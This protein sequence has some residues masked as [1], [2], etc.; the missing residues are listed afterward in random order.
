MLKLNNISKKFSNFELKDISFEVSAGEYFVILGKSGAGKSV[1]LELIAGLLHPDKGKIYQENKNITNLKIQKRNFGLVFQNHSLFP[2]MSVKENILYPLKAKKIYDKSSIDQLVQLC[3]LMGIKK[4]L[5]QK[6]PTLSIGE[7]QRVALARTLISNPQCILLDEPLS[8]LD[9]QSKTE[10]K[11]LLRKINEIDINNSQRKQTVIHVT[12]DYEE[13]ISL[14]DKV[15]VIEDGTV[16][17]IGTPENVFRHPKTEFIANF[18]GIKNFFKGHIKNTEKA[19]ACFIPDIDNDIELFIPS[20]YKSGYGSIIIKSE[21]ITISTEKYK[22]SARN[23]FSGLITDIEKIKNGIEVTLLVN[24]ILISAIITQKSMNE[25]KLE[26]NKH[27]YIN[28]KANAI[29]FIK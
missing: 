10:I 7:S 18:V 29:K 25:L 8:S 16:S 15:A 6:P 19:N 22:S 28:F 2:H 24:K 17:Q 3:S 9:I 26:I 11:S 5:H 21:D 13:A 1:L 27:V 20:E 14:A 4:L 12:H 23:V